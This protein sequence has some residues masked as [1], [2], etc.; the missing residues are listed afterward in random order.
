MPARPPEMNSAWYF[1]RLTATPSESAALGFS[2]IDRNRKPH[3]V[4]H[5]TNAE[6]GTSA[7]AITVI[8]D[9]FT[10]SPRIIPDRSETK[11]H[12]LSSNQPS[13]SGLSQPKKSPPAR[14]GTV[15]RPTRPTF[16][17]EVAEPPA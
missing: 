13:T 9:R 7:I 2:P 5:S 11:N 10:M 14:N 6:I 15:K 1:M 12:P 17:P 4:R 16:G 3:E 8:H